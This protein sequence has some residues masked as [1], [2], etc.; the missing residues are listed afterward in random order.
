M[1]K[2][3]FLKGLP[4]SGKSTF[5]KEQELLGAWRVNKDD[6]RLSMGLVGSAWSPESEKKVIDMRDYL[7]EGAF[8]RGVEVVISDDTNFAPKHEQRLRGLAKRHGAK[9]EIKYFDTP[10]EICVARDSAR[11]KPVGE[12]VIYDMYEKYVLERGELP[13]RPYVDDP[14]LPTTIICDLDGTLALFE[15]LRG[16]FDYARC[17][18]DK[19]NRP[20][21]NILNV[22]SESWA[23]EGQYGSQVTYLSGREDKARETTAEFLNRNRCPPGP[24]LMRATGD[25]R[26]DAVIKLELFDKH[27]RGKFRVEFVLDD[28]DR[29]VKM[30]RELGLTCLQVNYGAF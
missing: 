26:N 28:R 29:V 13:P 25:F 6:I 22:F 3:L 1:A 16:P 4:G 30:W 2:L 8:R 21:L 5:A 15:G 24:L 12:K 20:V 17:A 9:F 19:V 23:Q 7:I 18:G 10:L 27:I 14:T 11:P